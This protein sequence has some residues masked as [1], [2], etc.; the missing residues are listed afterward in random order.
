[1]NFGWLSGK[2][3]RTKARFYQWLY[4]KHEIT[5]WQLK[6]ALLSGAKSLL[7]G[8]GVGFGVAI[9]FSTQ[10]IVSSAMEYATFPQIQAGIESLRQDVHQNPCNEFLRNQAAE[11]NKRIAY[12]QR[13]NQ[14][15]LSDWASP[16]GWL[17]VERI[18]VRCER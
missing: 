15:W 4:E 10:S 9:A 8:V 14:R 17:D 16:D 1:M 12:E 11:T 5:E 3:H 2:W 6:S 18:E 7:T 13:S